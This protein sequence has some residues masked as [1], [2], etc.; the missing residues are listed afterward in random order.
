MYEELNNAFPNQFWFYA[1]D[2]LPFADAMEKCVRLTGDPSHIV[3][4]Q[5]R[6]IFASTHE[7]S[8]EIPWLTLI[9]GP[10]AEAPVEE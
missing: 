2:G 9:G 3:T 8:N 10:P 7:I 5:G 4:Y 1:V 6:V